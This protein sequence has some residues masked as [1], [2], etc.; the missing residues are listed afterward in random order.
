MSEK[1]FL[2]LERMLPEL[3][4]YQERGL[5]SK[6]EL[7]KII[8]TRKKHESRLQRVDKKLLDFV[9][10][11]NSETS[12][13]KIRDKRLRKYSLKRTH[14][15]T[16]ISKRVV[17]LYKNALEKFNE[18]DLIVDF[19][20]YAKKKQMVADMKDVYATCC[21][22]NPLDVD[23]WIYCASS[24][25]EMEDI[26]GARALFFKGIRMNP[27]NMEIRK[28]FFRMEVLYIN[29]VCKEAEG[30]DDEDEILRGDVPY[31]IFLDTLDVCRDEDTL[32]EM[33]KMSE[34]N[35]QLS[36]RIKVE[37]SK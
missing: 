9:R 19:T 27:T 23:L 8:E 37:L 7:Q 12:L 13:E 22:K 20:E 35:N 6:S 18:K 31:N 3:E 28:E 15:D 4:D 21:L 30:D 29:R 1:V 2:N 33:Y 11:I 14:Q 10:Y 36:S 5:F 26:D 24:L 16:K 34:G 32:L 17:M 25:F